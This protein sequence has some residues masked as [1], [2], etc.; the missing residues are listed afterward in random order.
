MLLFRLLHFL[1]WWE[2]LRYLYQGI[3]SPKSEYSGQFSKWLFNMRILLCHNYYQQPGG[4]D[5]VFEDEGALLE[6]NGHEVIRYN[7]HNDDI[8]T[9]NK[10]E[11]LKST[12]W[13]SSTTAELTKL[14]SNARPDVMHC[15]NTF[16]LISPSAYHAAK[17]LN[18]AVV[19]TLHNYRTICPKAVLYRDGQICEKCLGRKIAFP[20]VIHGCY[21]ESRVASAAVAMMLAYHW[22]TGIWTNYVDQYI[23]LSEH[24]KHKF[25]GGGLPANKISVKPNFVRLDP[26]I[27]AGSGNYAIFVGRLSEEKGIQSLLNAWR[28]LSADLQLKILGD[29]PLAGLVADAAEADNR[30]DWLGHQSMEAVNSLIGEA[31]F[32]IMPSVWYEPFG[33]SMIEAFAKGTPVIASRIGAMQEIVSHNETGFLYKTGD[34]GELAKIAQL[35]LDQPDLLRQMRNAARMEYERKYCPESNYEQLIRI[36]N[37]AIQTN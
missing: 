37:L 22:R 21:R 33:L 24:S 15:G 19:Q 13:N 18:V 4:E 14:I 36:Y 27:G 30:I 16:P 32:L 20:A 25:V 17:K 31:K 11:L 1:V 2:N 26:G 8:N 6:S 10:F 12:I 7:R 35:A 5:K 9:M 28:I 23:V 3:V 29:G 34:A